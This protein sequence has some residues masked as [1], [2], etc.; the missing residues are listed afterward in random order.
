MNV[1]QAIADSLDKWKIP[2]SEMFGQTYDGA[3]GRRKGAATR[4][5]PHAFMCGKVLQYS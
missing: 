2:G 5:V 3:G 1:N 4:F